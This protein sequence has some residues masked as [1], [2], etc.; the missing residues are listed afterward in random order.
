[1]AIKNGDFIELNFTGKVADSGEIFDTNVKEDAQKANLDVKE[2]KPFVLSVGHS[3]L[4][5]GLDEN[6]I[7]KEE[8][9]NYSVEIPS[10]KAFGNRN[11]QLIKMIPTRFFHEQK[12]EPQRGMQLALDGQL[13]KILSSSGGRTLVDFNH[14]LSGKKVNYEYKIN[15]LVTDEKEKIEALSEFF[16]RKKFDFE[17]KDDQI[18][19]KIE[20]GAQSFFKIFA[21][22]IEEILGLKVAFEEKKIESKDANA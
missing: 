1:M 21:K 4:P 22:K 3:M 10:E 7:G 19:F 14:P 13:V 11:P 2:I 15:R 8:G 16:F 9:K 5:K 18:I 12:I 17:R 20:K 6:L